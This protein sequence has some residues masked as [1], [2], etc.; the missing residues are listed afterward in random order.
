M[1]CAAVL[2]G[3]PSAQF[4]LGKGRDNCKELFDRV[5]LSTDVSQDNYFYAG[6]ICGYWT[7][8]NCPRYM[9][10]KYFAG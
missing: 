6:Y 7:R 9:Q 4:A 10:E 8:D 5:L 2:A 3:V 1:R